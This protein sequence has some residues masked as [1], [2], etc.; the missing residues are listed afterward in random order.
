VIDLND[1]TWMGAPLWDKY[2][3]LVAE[4][5]TLF[6]AIE[7]KPADPAVF[8]SLVRHSVEKGREIDVLVGAFVDLCRL[9]EGPGH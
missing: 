3:G 5:R 7:A 2:R 8:L 9:S 4:A 1:P 6:Q